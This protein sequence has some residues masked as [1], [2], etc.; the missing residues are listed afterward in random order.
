MAVNITT[1]DDIRN[2]A[3]SSNNTQTLN[4]QNDIDLNNEYPYGVSTVTIRL[5]IGYWRD[6]GTWTID[7]D[8]GQGGRYKIKNLRTL[9]ATP[10]SIF[11]MSNQ[12][13]PNMKIV[14]KNID[15]VN[16]ILSGA[17]FY[18]NGD[19]TGSIEFINCRFVGCRTGSAYLINKKTKITCTSCYFDMPWY[20]ANS[21]VYT[22]TSLIPAL[23]DTEVQSLTVS[24]LPTAYYC[25][26]HETY[27]GWTVATDFGNDTANWVLN[28]DGLIV[29]SC[30]CFCMHGCY[31]DGKVYAPYTVSSGIQSFLYIYHY[32]LTMLDWAPIV[33]NVVD[34]NWVVTYAGVQ[35]SRV[36]SCYRSV[37]SCVFKKKVTRANG[38]DWTFES[39]AFD[40]S[41]VS[42][43]ATTGSSMPNP[44]MA[45]PEQME[46]TTW[47][48]TQ[49]FPIIVPSTT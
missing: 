6:S 33:P 49:G 39:S 31:M 26:F 41:K 32:S 14:F 5:D 18:I 4:L 47:L 29:T 20:G 45:T 38:T 46:D 2:N 15:F 30:Q 24:N 40:T 23:N 3:S 19:F 21:N 44:I 28:A 17:D 34:I 8:N 13:N 7:G 1:W 35:Y 42:S 9:I 36:Y 43:P 37:F 16:L 12:D 22:Y 48:Q 25:W 11:N 27:G 10:Q